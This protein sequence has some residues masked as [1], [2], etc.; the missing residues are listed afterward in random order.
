[1]LTYL[2]LISKLRPLIDA[3][4][5]RR[6]AVVYLFLLPLTGDMFRFAEYAETKESWTNPFLGAALYSRWSLF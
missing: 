6:M 3:A 1:M 2:L 4:A 5:D